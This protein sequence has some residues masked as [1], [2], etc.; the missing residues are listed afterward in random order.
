MKGDA[1]MLDD[2]LNTLL[3][4][5]ESKSFTKAAEKLAL[6]QPA[7]SNHIN[8][9][10][11]ECNAKLFMRGKH[12]FKLTPEGK[13]AIMYARRLKALHEKM[14]SDIENE[15]KHISNFRIGITHTSENNNIT[16]TLAKYANMHPNITITIITDAIKNLYDKLENYELDIAI[17]DGKRLSLN[18]NYLMLDTDYLVCAV[19]NDNPLANQNMITVSELKKQ[20]MI[21]RL[22][23]SATRQLFEATLISIN[24]S[25]EN[26]NVSLEVDNVSTIKQ[27]VVKD[28]GVSILPQ[29]ACI[30]DARKGKIS[31][32]PVENLSMMREMNIAYN[33]DFAHSEVLK[34]IVELYNKVTHN[35]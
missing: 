23:T 12:E 35:A 15:K 19:S 21:L 27:L 5:A 28:L 17:V 25:I 31:I 20:N 29:S 10:E 6:T 14:L 8:Q 16:E 11:K 4:L 13:I 3:V 18:L 26:F 33:K 30:A 22:P 34:D 32:L 24:E 2:K 1:I 9:L 7:V